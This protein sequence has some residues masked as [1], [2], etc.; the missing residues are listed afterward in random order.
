MGIVQRLATEDYV[1]DNCSI[2]EFLKAAYP[3]G[4]IYISTV[5]TN[6][7]IL[8]GFGTWQQVKDVFLLSA[9]D[10]YVAGSIGGE[11][12][13]VLTIDEMPSHNH[14][15]ALSDGEYTFDKERT[16]ISQYKVTEVGWSDTTTAYF[17]GGGQPHNN[18][19]LILSSMSGSGPNDEIN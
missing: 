9:G 2:Q 19:H 1:K 5:E 6:P 14:Q 3:L 13:H 7:A 16:A 4:A 17:V 11:N 10:T 8:F 15:I 18:M 12:E